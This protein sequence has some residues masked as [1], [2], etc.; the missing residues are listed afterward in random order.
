MSLESYISESFESGLQYNDAAQLCLRLF[1]S[2]DDVPAKYHV[3][4]NKDNLSTVFANLS[5]NGLIIKDDDASQVYKA[6]SYSIKDNYH[7]LTVIDS[8]FNV[9]GTVDSAIGNRLICHITSH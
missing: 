6:E 8:I 4:C 7:W 3:E 9:G 5:A 1:C 2:V